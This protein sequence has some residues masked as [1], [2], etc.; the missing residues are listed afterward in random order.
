[1]NPS[2]TNRIPAAVA[3]A[4]LA[5]TATFAESVT[6]R[7][8]PEVGSTQKFTLTQEQAMTMSMGP[9]GE[10]KTSAVNR[11]EMTQKVLGVA[12]N[13]DVTLEFTYD[14]A[15]MEVESPQ[16][17]MTVDSAEPG[18]GATDNPMTM[19]IGK[20]IAVTLSDRA[21]VKGV[22]GLDA[23]F[24]ELA[25]AAEAEPSMAPVLEMLRASFSDESMAQTF[26][27]SFP[28]LPEEAV[29]EGSTW[30]WS[31]EMSNPAFGTMTLNQSFE[32]LGFEER[33]GRD[34]VKTAV[35]LSMEHEGTF[36]LLDKMRET[37]AGQGQEIDMSATLG[38]STGAGT[39]WL[40]RATGMTVAMDTTSDFDMT[41]EIGIPGMP[42]DAP[43]GGKM[44]MDMDMQIRQLVELAE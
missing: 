8:R 36:P 24:E 38:K 34:C 42:A 14:R 26:Q 2:L 40:D 17:A 37:M 25:S 15:V 9:M 18:E 7:I 22:T 10:Q 28:V 35:Q 21:E 33:S 3:I 44:R 32:V 11:L 20:P 43:G 4:V 6:L 30:T 12:D 5:V 13:G 16:G 19:I 31:G 41:M 23:M 29:G 27:Q 1:M 39:V